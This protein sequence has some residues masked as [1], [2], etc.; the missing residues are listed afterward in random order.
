MVSM[1]GGDEVRGAAGRLVRLNESGDEV[2]C[3]GGAGDA[4]EKPPEEEPPP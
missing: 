3:D 1:G 2:P 4:F